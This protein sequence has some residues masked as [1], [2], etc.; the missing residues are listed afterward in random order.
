MTF[1]LYGI[2]PVP[3]WLVVSGIFAYDSYTTLK[4]TVSSGSIDVPAS[5][6]SFL[7]WYHRFCWAY[8]WVVGGRWLLPDTPLS[9]LLIRVRPPFL[10][11]HGIIVLVT[12]PG[13]STQY[14]QYK[15]YNPP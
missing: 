7:E 4:D 8:R 9:H 3:A 10:N 15:P 13:T 12:T 6:T 5:L 2:I 14:I 11:S 1:Q